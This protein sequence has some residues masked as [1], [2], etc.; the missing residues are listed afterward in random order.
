MANKMEAMR[1]KAQAQK[2]AMADKMVAAAKATPVR[3]SADVD[4][5]NAVK[6]QAQ[7]RK[8]AMADKMVAAAKAKP[9]RPMGGGMGSMAGR[10][11]MGM[12]AGMGMK[13]GGKAKGKK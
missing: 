12:G 11:G 9:A 1:A 2:S 5:I 3:Q 8:S 10:G 13:K 4:K 7:A 6:A